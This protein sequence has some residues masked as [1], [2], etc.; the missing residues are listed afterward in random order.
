MIWKFR[1]IHPFEKLAIRPTSFEIVPSVT[2]ETVQIHLEEPKKFT[3]ETDGGL[4]DALF[5][6][7]S[8]RIKKPE[9]QRSAL[10]VVKS[11]TWQL[12]NCMTMMLFI[13]KKAVWSMGEYMRIVARIFK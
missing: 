5:V 13:W 11:I 3:V 1:F 7:C 4:H 8:R 12:W 10:N 6:L 9:I 2:G